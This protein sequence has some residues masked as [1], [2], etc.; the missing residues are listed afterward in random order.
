MNQYLCIA[1]HPN[2]GGVTYFWGGDDCHCGRFW[3]AALMHL[4]RCGFVEK[5]DFD[6]W[7]NML[8]EKSEA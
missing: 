7:W 3:R 5:E 6:I 1:D 2:I 8:I 4:M